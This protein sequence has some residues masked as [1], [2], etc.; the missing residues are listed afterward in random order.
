[1]SEILKFQPR[2]NPQDV[3]CEVRAAVAEAGFSPEDVAQASGARQEKI[4]LLQA[5]FDSLPE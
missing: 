4:R 3:D 2:V 1:M 5:L